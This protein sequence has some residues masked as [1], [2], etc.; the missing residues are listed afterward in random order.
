METM[1]IEDLAD[2]NLLEAIRQHA[3]WQMTLAFVE[4][5]GMIFLAGA[6][7]L[8][9]AFR[10][11]AARTQK[12]VVPSH[13]IAQVRNFFA[14]R[15]R[16][17]S[18]LVRLDRDKDLEGLLF[19]QGFRSRYSTPCMVLTKPLR[20]ALVPEG[21]SIER[22]S[23]PRHVF[24]AIQVWED[25]YRKIHLPPSETRLYFGNTSGLLSC[26]VVGV[27]AYRQDQPLASGLAILS[28]ETSG[29]YW[30]ATRSDATRQGL[31]EMVTRLL[32][33]EAF[34]RGAS[35]VTLQ[36]TP[37]AE[38]LYRRLGFKTYDYMKWYSHT[39]LD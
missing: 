17:F 21:I 2:A 19:D 31:G 35:V 15:S 3:C 10:N 23:T 1:T 20:E 28:G 7:G 37:F 33:N 38:S 9:M 6:N 4:Q 12:S 8:P 25:A 26:S 5:S 14:T 34:A 11:C 30:I 39:L 24:D 27:V 36:A 32:T 29:L 13:F 16:G 22:M 18:I